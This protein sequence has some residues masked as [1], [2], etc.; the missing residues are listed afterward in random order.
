MRVVHC[1]APACAHRLCRGDVAALA[2]ATSTGFVAFMLVADSMQPRCGQ[3]PQPQ[4]GCRTAG[5]PQPGMVAFAAAAVLQGQCGPG[6][7]CARGHGADVVRNVSAVSREHDEQCRMVSGGRWAESL[8]QCRTEGGRVAN[9]RQQ[10]AR[11][12]GAPAR[13][14]LVDCARLPVTSSRCCLTAARLTSALGPYVEKSM[15]HSR[16]ILHPTLL[17]T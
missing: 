1:A 14:L 4:G 7:C 10:C 17:H 11:C 16:C 9:V 12:G 8:P 5:S 6:R 15:P 13:L 3:L 2:L